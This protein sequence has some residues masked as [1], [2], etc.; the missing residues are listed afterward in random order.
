[1]STMIRHTGR[2]SEALL[3]SRVEPSQ[4]P[5]MCTARYQSPLMWHVDKDV[6][7]RS[8]PRAAWLYSPATCDCC[9]YLLLRPF[10]VT[11][12]S[13]RITKHREAAAAPL[14][15]CGLSL[16]CSSDNWELTDTGYHQWETPSATRCAPS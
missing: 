12:L 16:G 4:N 15:R 1:M 8:G 14:P 13:P 2:V 11:L 3:E 7:L 6:S 10:P 9:V 5:M